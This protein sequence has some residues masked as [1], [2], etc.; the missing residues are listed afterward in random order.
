M[1][2]RSTLSRVEDLIPAFALPREKIVSIFFL[3]T[4][5]GP[6][7]SEILAPRDHQSSHARSAAGALVHTSGRPRTHD[8]LTQP[9]S[10]PGPVLDA[11]KQGPICQNTEKHRVKNV[12]FDLYIS[13]TPN[14]DSI[15]AAATWYRQYEDDG[16][17]QHSFESEFPAHSL[18][19]CRSSRE[20]GVR[21]V[22]VCVYIKAKA[23]PEGCF[24]RERQWQRPLIPMRLFTN[25]RGLRLDKEGHG[26]MLCGP[27][28]EVLCCAVPC[29][30]IDFLGGA[31]SWE[32]SLSFLWRSSSSSMEDEANLNAADGKAE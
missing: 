9:E 7:H 22:C 10:F 17:D 5:R 28:R 16:E 19:S 20:G 6:N 8:H 29:R 1:G 12:R 15:P 18:A 3:L 13:K 27:P 25:Q 2:V 4:N 32:N 31:L 14:L 23:E 11:Q 24:L 26:F 30:G 21:F